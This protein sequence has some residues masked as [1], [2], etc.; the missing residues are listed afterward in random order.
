MENTPQLNYGN[1]IRKKLL[2]I[3]GISTLSL[4]GLTGLPF[5]PIYRLMMAI[6]FGITFLSFLFPLYAYYMFSQKGGRF[7]EK[8]YN[9]IIERLDVPGKSHI[10]DIGSGNGVLA[11]QLAQQLPEAQVT[12]MDYWGLNWEYSKSVCEENARKGGVAT[13]VHFQKG[14]A[15]QLEFADAT[16]YGAISNLTFHEVQSAADKREVVREALRVIKPG[17]RFAFVDYFYET[18]YYGNPTE[19]EAF[20]KGL[21]LAQ[22]EYKPLRDLL[23]LPVLLRHPKILGKVG[24]IYGTKR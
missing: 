7:Q 9:L 24:M 2:I 21:N 13:R 8:V 1:W 11:V 23:T 14:D 4:G 18:K 20:L 12:G 19:F 10:L 16:F 22:F 3:L 15:A 5:G 6:L 17:G